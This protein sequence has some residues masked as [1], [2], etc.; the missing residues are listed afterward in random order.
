MIQTRYSYTV[1][2]LRTDGERS[3]GDE[4]VNFLQSEGI[5]LERSA[6]NTPAQ[7]G[8][9][10][11]AGRTILTVARALRIHARLPED[12][13]PSLVQTAGYL[14]NRTPTFSLRWKTPFEEIHSSQPDLSHLHVIG[15]KTFILQYG[16]PRARKLAPRT[17]AG[18]L[19][20]YD[21]TNIFLLWIPTE[22]RIVRSRDVTFTDQ[23]YHPTQTPLEI[24]QE[25]QLPARTIEVH[26]QEMS[27][28]DNESDIGDTIIPKQLLPTKESGTQK[29]PQEVDM[30]PTPSL[31]PTPEP[32]SSQLQV[33]RQ[34]LSNFSQDNVLPEG[35]RRT[36]RPRHQAYH[37]ILD[38]VDTLVGYHSA[39]SGGLTQPGTQRLHQDTL[40]PPPKN[41]RQM[42]QHPFVEQ[43]K[44]AAQAEYDELNTQGTFEAVDKHRI[45]HRILPLMWNFTYKLDSDGYLTRF[46]ARICVR[47]DLQITQQE[48]YAATL[49]SNVFRTLMAVAAA[50]DLDITQ[51]DAINAFLNSPI[52]DEIYVYFPEGYEV[53]GKILR[54]LK[55][56]YGLKQSPLLWYRHF[57]AIL[58]QL[59]FQEVPGVNCL[60]RND[61]LLVL[62]YVDDILVLNQS[63]DREKRDQFLAA[64]HQRCK[65]RTLPVANWFLGIRIVRDRQRRLLWLCQDA[66]IDKIAT[67]FNIDTYG[68]A[69]ST[70]LSGTDQLEPSDNQATSQE[71]LA[72]QQRIGSINFAATMTR[73]DIAKVCSV[74]AQ[75]LHNPS[76]THRRAADRVIAYLLFTKTQAIQYG[77]DG[78]PECYADAAFADNSDRRSSS[79]YLF[80]LY[81]GPICWS[82]TKQQTVT[83]S[84]TEAEF[85][86]LAD[87]CKTVYAENRLFQSISLP[88]GTNIAITTVYSD[89]RQTV[90]LLH[91]E[92]IKLSTK[93][94]HV[95]IHQHWLRQEVQKGILQ[96]KWV[97]TLEMVA[98]GLTKVLPGQRFQRFMLQLGMK[99]VQIPQS[100]TLRNLGGC[101]TTQGSTL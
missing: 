51:L 4:A 57:C 10:E 64:L 72:Y 40:P 35:S 53:T 95:D 59:G 29:A 33:T 66:Y 6:A 12:L 84:T 75:F 67:K 77:I 41:W 90:R 74:L 39:F 32:Q 7:N 60:L 44:E 11:R 100:K 38:S 3:L 89:N 9:A 2:F 54:L 79:G 71:I 50:K 30:L 1:R 86:A 19:L 36:R 27:D 83:T 13:W 97:P 45:T 69:P 48:T 99:T 56:L 91:Q 46:K 26:E 62:F 65:L 49:A 92:T 14:L 94:K 8:H 5:T 52:D 58:T 80:K 21:S 17:K 61:Y 18:Y 23:L 43:F 34:T 70:P 73:P 88:T 22:K 68:R 76:E 78:N 16:I 24:D 31:T 63:K 37:T 96:I 101:V 85:L 28:N 98:D 15:C 47:G 93:L 20:G 55:A 25:L 82:A 81:G 42:L 87:A